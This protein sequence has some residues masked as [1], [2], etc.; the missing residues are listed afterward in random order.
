VQIT[1]LSFVKTA[2]VYALTCRPRVRAVG[3]NRPHAA[4]VGNSADFVRTISK[5]IVSDFAEYAVTRVV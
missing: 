1:K 3:S 5:D 4:P 2:A